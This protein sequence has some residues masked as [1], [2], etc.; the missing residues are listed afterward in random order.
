M[1]CFV[2]PCKNPVPLAGRSV[3]FTADACGCEPSA[4]R[5]L[6][7]GAVPSLQTNCSPVAA[8]PAVELLTF[9]GACPCGWGCEP[10]AQRPLTSGAVPSLQTNC[11]PV[12]ATPA[13][14]LLTFSGAVLAAGAVSHQHK[15]R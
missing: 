9:S 4:Q 1:S 14:E 7:S 13:V 6:T 2:V 15:D 8:T 11:S 3:S 10:S 12:V 5:P